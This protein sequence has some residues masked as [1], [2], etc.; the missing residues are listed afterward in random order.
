[1]Q[2]QIMDSRLKKMMGLIRDASQ[3]LR[4][5]VEYPERDTD[6]EMYAEKFREWSAKDDKVKKKCYLFNDA[7]KA[8][9][10]RV[11]SNET[12]GKPVYDNEGM[13]KAAG[14]LISL[15]KIV[16]DE[17]RFTIINLECFRTPFKIVKV[18]I[19]D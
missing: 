18:E 4:S 14:Y 17:E 11:S 16:K 7:M 3:T 6:E 2:Q 10:C 9:V 19:E 12:S 1:M 8:I 13:L 15:V 5:D